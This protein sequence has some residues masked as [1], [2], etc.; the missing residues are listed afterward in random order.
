MTDAPIAAKPT[1]AWRRW[2]PFVLA[3]IAVAAVAYSLR[4]A[5]PKKTLEAVEGLGASFLLVLVP[6][7]VGTMLHTWAWQLLT[8]SQGKRP[9][10]LSMLSIMLTSEAV[11]MTLPAGP[12]L[13]ESSSVLFLR[14]R[15]GVPASKGLAS[16]A[17][18]K[19]LVTFTNGIAILAAVGLGW[20]MITAASQRMTHGPW[21]VVFLV[22]CAVML[23]ALSTGMAL[24]LLSRKTLAR[25]AHY[26]AK[27]PIRPLRRFLASKEEAISKADDH[28]A[29]PFTS[30]R[31]L[32][33]PG[34]LLFAQWM[35]EAADTA[36]ILYLLGVPLGFLASMSAELTGA[37]LRA[38]A[39]LIP[40]G[41][42]VQ[43]AGY[44]KMFDA[45]SGTRL[46]TLGAAFVLVKRAK[47]LVWIGI[48]Y[49][50]LLRNRRSDSP[51]P[52]F[53]ETS[54]PSPRSLEGDGE[55]APVPP[56][57]SGRRG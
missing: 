45:L 4:D 53:A 52:V 17:A 11:R 57:P 40:A 44:V 43:D 51:E 49:L 22:V 41:L 2:L 30:A 33:L 27:L 20:S 13:A 21:L 26:L 32:I 54:P 24:A 50:L 55:T 56:L 14:D 25:G 19:A 38:F 29:E 5:D 16:I 15:H 3:A 7:A 48:G 12:A 8:S 10:F 47:E 36:V 18:K 46:A 28:L 31:S 42:G 34:V 39:F 35:T 37:L 9:P 6:Y 23:F 1:P